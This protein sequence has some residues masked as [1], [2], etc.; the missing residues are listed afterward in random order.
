MPR[1]YRYV[2]ALVIVLFY[3]LARIGE[4]ES[5]RLLPLRYLWRQLRCQTYYLNG[6]AA[7]LFYYVWLEELPALLEDVG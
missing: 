3:R 1:D 6:L 4:L 2:A 5:F 7:N